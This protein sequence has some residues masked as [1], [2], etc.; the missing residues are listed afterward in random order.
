MREGEGR[1][2]GRNI[3]DGEEEIGRDKREEWK[4]GGRRRN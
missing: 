4:R 1:W 3:R 2:R